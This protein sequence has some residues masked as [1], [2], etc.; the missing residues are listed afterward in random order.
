M[1]GR[2]TRYQGLPAVVISKW[3]INCVFPGVE[4]VLANAFRPVN[5]LISELLPTLE[6]PMKVY[7]GRSASGHSW[8]LALDLTNA[9]LSTEYSSTLIPI[10]QDAVE[11]LGVLHHGSVATL[12]DPMEVG[13]RQQ[14]LELAGYFRRRNGIVAAPY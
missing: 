11:F 5:I 9:G 10:A 1:P 13:I 14:G 12:V 4:L 7:S 3:L 2:S 8:S 6:R